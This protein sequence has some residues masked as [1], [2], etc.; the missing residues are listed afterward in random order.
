MT[1]NLL[2]ALLAGKHQIEVERSKSRLILTELK[3]GSW[4]Q[5]LVDYNIIVQVKEW[6]DI[7]NYIRCSS[8]LFMD[9]YQLVQWNIHVFSCNYISGKLSAVL[10]VLGLLLLFGGFGCMIYGYVTNKQEL[11]MR[12]D[13]V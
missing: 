7:S 2:D 13:E 8:A 6:L 11:D 1:K 9:A 10:M 3:K 4:I 12:E 5:Q